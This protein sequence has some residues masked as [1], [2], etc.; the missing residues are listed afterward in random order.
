MTAG[1]RTQTVVVIGDLTID[2]NLARSRSLQSS[3]NLWNADDRTRTYVQPGG[4][5]LVAGLLEG[6]AA[7]SNPIQLYHA[8]LPSGNILPSDNTIHHSYAIWGAYPENAKSPSGEPVWRVEEFL[9]LDRSLGVSTGTLQP[10]KDP[11]SA[12]VIVLD[13]AGLGFRDHPEHWPG[14]IGNTNANPWVVLKMAKP[15]A[16]GQL[17]KDLHEKWADRLIVILTVNDLRL[18]EVQISRRLSWE[19]TAQDLMWELI[20]NPR[21]NS[22]SNCAHVIVSFHTSGAFLLSRVQ[23]TK[24]K[25]ETHQATLFFDPRNVEGMWEQNYEGGMVGYTTCL[26]AGVVSQLLE[27]LPDL[28]LGIQGGLAAIRRLHIDG[29]GNRTSDITKADLVFPVQRIVHELKKS[30]RLFSEVHVQDPVRSLHRLE[31]YPPA[32]PWTI[33]EERYPEGLDL[34]A[35]QIVLE[36]ADAALQDV[37]MGRFGKLLTVDRKEIESLRSIGAL[38]LEYCNQQLQERPLSIAVFGSPGSGKSF[39]ITEMAKSLSGIRKSGIK[40]RTFNLSQFQDPEQL[41]DALHQVRDIGLSGSIPLVFWDEF[42]TKFGTQELGWLR[43][44]LAPMQDGN[45]Q[46]GQITHSIGPAIFVFAGGTCHSMDE[47]NKG[48]QDEGFRAA[49]GPDFVSRLKGH[50]DIMGPNPAGKHISEDPYFIIRR[51]ILLR[52]LLERGTPQLFEKPGKGRLRIDPGV[53]R[54]FLHTSR[55]KHGARSMESILAT[56]GLSGNK[57]FERSSLPPSSQLNIHVDGTEFL[58]LVQQI[59]LTPDILDRLAAAAHKVWMNGKLRDGYVYGPQKSET[60][61]TSPLLLD[62]EDLPE[63]G[64]EANRVNVR[65]IPQKLAAASYVMIPSRSNQPALEFPG[66]DLETLA[67]MEHR[68]WMEAKFAAGWKPGKPTEEDPKRNEYLVP[69]DEVPEPIKKSDRDLVK[70]IPNILR[71]A[72]YAVERIGSKIKKFDKQ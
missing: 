67:E 39:G 56:S 15:I 1:K 20:H 11:E 12:D 70:G 69:W 13:D 6:L 31:S 37:P 68:L 26:T 62:Y 32:K 65:T 71:E 28:P 48:S 7:E 4:S 2:W 59:Q 35:E 9:G 58:S 40:K 55:Y 45:F 30:E 53:L 38:V 60:E 34:L 57:T 44:F 14:C 8:S 25:T 24:S 47:F 22:L 63:W 36:G 5:A 61:K 17:W 23:D 51:A 19:K 3:G 29:Y 64:K 52:S 42:D 54:A 16:E 33:L 72:G 49:K 46:R 10:D 18:T 66:D 21:V 27:S 41:Y 43:Y 50:V